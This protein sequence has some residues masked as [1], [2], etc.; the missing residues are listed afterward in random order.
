MKKPVPPAHTEEAA[1]AAFED[2]KLL[3]FP[4]Q[5]ESRP[6]PTPPPPPVPPVPQFN[7]EDAKNIILVL[8][9][10]PLQ[11]LDEADAVRDS[12]VRF[13]NHVNSIFGAPAK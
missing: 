7:V 11:N 8:R 2:S 5:F 9:R 4:D 10:A 3:K 1:T 6:R 13:I 12:L